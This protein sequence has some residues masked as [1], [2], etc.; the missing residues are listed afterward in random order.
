MSTFYILLLNN[1]NKYIRK[2]NM[3]KKGVKICIHDIEEDT[4]YNSVELSTS[5]RH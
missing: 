2:G 1:G 4:L 3:Y 5:N